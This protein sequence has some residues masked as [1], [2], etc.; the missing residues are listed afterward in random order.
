M[1][2]AMQPCVKVI[3]PQKR[4]WP[5]RWNP[6]FRVSSAHSSIPN[7]LRLLL[8]TA[9]SVR[10]LGDSPQGSWAICSPTPL[11]APHHLTVATL[12]LLEQWQFIS[13]QDLC[14]SQ[15]SGVCVAH[16]P[17][18]VSFQ[19]SFS[20]EFFPDHYPFSVLYLI[21]PVLKGWKIPNTFMCVFTKQNS[22]ENWDFVLFPS[23]FLQSMKMPDTYHMLGAQ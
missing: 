7:I 18:Q 4:S 6:H 13:H 1:I 23:V 20:W 22:T 9:V 12:S 2:S 19:L 21:T 10:C 14:T 11:R 8:T 15:H 16:S 3:W 17:S 5:P